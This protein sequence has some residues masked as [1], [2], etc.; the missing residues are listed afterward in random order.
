MIKCTH[1]NQKS[2]EPALHSSDDKKDE[3]YG[4]IVDYFKTVIIEG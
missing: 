2:I 1:E 4:D 3:D